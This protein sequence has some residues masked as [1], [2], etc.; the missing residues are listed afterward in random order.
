LRELR[1]EVVR[2]WS[3][4]HSEY[5]GKIGHFSIGWKACDQARGMVGDLMKKNQA[6]IGFD[7]ATLGEGA[8]FKMDRKKFV[9]LADVPDYV[10][11]GTRQS[12]EPMQHFADIDIQDIDGGP[13]L[14]SRCV[15][16]D[17]NISATEWK[18]YFDGFAAAKVGPDEGT[19]PFR[20]WQIWEDM[21]DYL[22]KKD[23]LRFVAAAGILA[24]YVGDASQPLHCS[25][26]HHGV[27]PMLKHAG[28]KYPVP[29]T[30]NGKDNKA[31]ADFHKTPEA[32]IHA[33][34]EEGMFEVE[35]AAV[36]LLSGVTTK[37]RSKKS[38]EVAIDSGHD[39]AVEVIALMAR[40]QKALPPMEII[41]ADDP[42]LTVKDRQAA[43]WAN[44]KIR[45]ATIGLLADSV[46]VLADLWESAWRVGN[47]KAVPAA[48]R[49]A[50]SEGELSKVY[51]TEKGFLRSLTLQSMASSQRFEP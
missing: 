32:K 13:S 4:G 45:R 51:R 19:L 2:N 1:V 31:Y 15:K 8:A 35:G 7:D 48:K 16:D 40:A 25:Y 36:E 34:Y 29:K 39:A 41:R 23:T 21:V 37:L 22:K 24:H 30:L 46:Q 50:F 27:P 20:V 17:A 28:R 12:N 42:D 10:W 33:I 44:K 26:L 18:D 6:R 49:R 11:I 14:L 43:L 9:P 38:H 3:I 5:W 47:G